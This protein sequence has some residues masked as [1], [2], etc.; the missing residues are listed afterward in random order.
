MLKIISPK[1]HKYHQSSIDAFLDLLAIYQNFNLSDE[2]RKKSTFL[3]AEDQKHGV[4]GGALLYPQK[5]NDPRENES[6][7]GYEDTFHGSFVC[8]QPQVKE[9]WIARICYCLEVNFASPADDQNHCK[10]FY[11]ELYEAFLQFGEPKDLEFLAFSLCAFESIEPPLH[12]SWPYNMPIRNSEDTSGLF[13]GILSLKGTRFLPKY[14]R[15]RPSK[16]SASE[17]KTCGRFQ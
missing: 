5:V 9:F 16:R 12:E 13:H 14:P 8:F 17:E 2:R 1:G 15:N 11:E 6:L 3:I 7:E 4:Y 10:K